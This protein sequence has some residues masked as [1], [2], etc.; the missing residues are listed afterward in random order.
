MDT[1]PLRL[2]PRTSRPTLRSSLLRLATTA[3]LTVA[4]AV[5]Y[6]LL[7]HAFALSDARNLWRY[8]FGY[9]TVLAVVVI[10]EVA[11]RGGGGARRG[12]RRCR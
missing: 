10:I 11:G 3:A 7:V 9:M 2:D 6:V 8:A 12:S 4:C 5:G 1:R